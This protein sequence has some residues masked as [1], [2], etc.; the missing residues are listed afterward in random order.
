MRDTAGRTISVSIDERVFVNFPAIEI[1][2]FAASGI[3]RVSAAITSEGIEQFWSV[4]AALPPGDAGAEDSAIAIAA[5]HRWRRRPGEPGPSHTYARTVETRVRRLVECGL[6]EC[7]PVVALYTGISARHY[8]SCA[9]YDVDALPDDAIQ[10]RPARLL[11]DWF[12]PLGAQPNE[13]RQAPGDIVYAAG[14]TVLRSLFNPSDSRQTCLTRES[15]RAVF[16]AEALTSEQSPAVHAALG[17]LYQFLSDR[18]A[19]VSAPVFA[20]DARPQILLEL[21]EQDSRK[22]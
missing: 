15:A 13:V 3:T 12:V 22:W 6:M 16:L 21:D 9:G 18:G 2:G 17:E 1:G 7:V 14:R 20:N 4:A 10:L 5:S 11:S 8:V 19:R